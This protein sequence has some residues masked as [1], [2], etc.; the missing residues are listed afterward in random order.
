MQQGLLSAYNPSDASMPPAQQGYRGLLSRLEE[1]DKVGAGIN[2]YQAMAFG[3]GFAPSA[4]IS[5]VLGYAP[6]PNVIGGT[7]PSFTENMDQGNYIDAGLQTLGASGDVMLASAPFAP[8]LFAPAVGAKL[9]SQIGKGIRSASKV[10]PK[11]GLLGDV[12]KSSNVFGSV[13][14]FPKL[15]KAEENLVS[16]SFAPTNEIAGFGRVKVENINNRDLVGSKQRFDELKKLTADYKH[17]RAKATIIRLENGNS[18]IQYMQPPTEIKNVNI[19]DLI[20]TQD[21]IVLGTN[22]TSGS[23]LV[24]KKNGKFYIRDGHHRIAQKVNA[25]EQTT[26]VRVI[27][28]DQGGYYGM[29]NSEIK[30]P[31]QT[32]LLGKNNEIKDPLIVQH[33][34]NE[35][36]LLESDRLGGFPVP[37][38]AVSKVDNPLLGFGDVTLVGN[39][40]MAKPSGSNPVYRADAYTTRR[41]KPEIEVNKEAEAFAENN[42]TNVFKDIPKG[43]N[44]AEL[45]GNYNNKSIAED[46][47]RGFEGGDTSNISLRAKYM[48]D[49][50]LLNPKDFETQYD[51]IKFVRNNFAETEDYTNYI[52]KLKKDMIASGGNAKEKLFVTYTNNGR[53][54]LP[55]T[56]E[57]YV[58]LMKKKRGAGEETTFPS[59][60]ALRAKL[61]PKFRNITEVKSERNRVVNREKF[62]E[63]KNQVNLD[64]EDLLSDLSKKLPEKTD[65]RTSE[66]LFEDLILNKLGT[67]PYSKPYEPF[68]DDA[69]K[70]SASELRDKLKSIPTEYFEVKPQRAVGIE[71]FE[72]AIIPDNSLKSTEEILKRRGISKIFKY[73]SDEQRKELMKKF[74]EL[75][76][77]VG[78]LGLLTY[79]LSNEDNSSL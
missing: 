50:E 16:S 49:K 13:E 37:S 47:Y 66:E 8:I 69:I 41:P 71:E 15:S 19:S 65:W 11:T 48:I 1:R 62:E 45:D 21:N 22:K 57:N 42:V 3:A 60:G 5:D 39:P 36:A 64:Y 59:M 24:V 23:P 25:G 55:A 6:N 51:I 10:G 79:G 54:Y 9:I 29:D 30:I 18:A 56:L 33:N 68:I 76:F 31:N 2:P 67:H 72:G 7:L 34:I 40:N 70:K 78:G 74:P 52:T 77:S 35:T 63:V 26:D 32:G 53:K 73:G 27:D 14:S 46:L 12:N 44:V 4:G 17:D 75:M 58:K 20:A 38:L 28:L 61:T 43:S